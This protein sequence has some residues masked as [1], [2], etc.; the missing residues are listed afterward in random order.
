PSRAICVAR[1]SGCASSAREI[2]MDIEQQLREML[3]LKDP[4]ARFTDG[5]LA[6][7]GNVPDRQQRDGVVRLA[8]VR[9]TR[10]GRRILLGAL[11][12]VGAAAAM[13]PFMPGRD[14]DVPAS[15]QVAALVAPAGGAAADPAVLL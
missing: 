3:V 5:V 15:Q 7:L 10:R 14:N 12:V 6:R 13:L 9:N 11:V 8:D 1:C 4:G 2:P